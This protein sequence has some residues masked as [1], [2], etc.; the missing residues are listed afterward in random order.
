MSDVTFNPPVPRRPRWKLL[1][2]VSAAVVTVAF[3]SLWGFVPPETITKPVH[4]RRV[5]GGELASK[6]PLDQKGLHFAANVGT[7]NAKNNLSK[8]TSSDVSDPAWFRAESLVICN[9]SDHLLMDRV[10][11]FLLEFLKEKGN[12]EQIDYYPSGTHPDRGRIAPDLYLTLDLGRLAESGVVEKDLAAN[13]RLSLG[14][15]YAASN[16]SQNGPHS[17]P[18]ARL[19]A[20]LSLEHKSTLLGVESSGSRFSMQ[21]KDIAASLGKAVVDEIQSLRRK[22]SPLP[23]LPESSVPAYRESPQFRFLTDLDGRELVSVHGLMLHNETFWHLAS[24]SDPAAAM[25][26][27]HAELSQAEWKGSSPPDDDRS[28][29]LL[30]AHK[31]RRLEV[32][33]EGIGTAGISFRPGRPNQPSPRLLVRYTDSMTSAEIADWFGEALDE[34]DPD[35]ETLLALRRYGNNDQRL[36]LMERAMQQPPRTATGWLALSQHYEWKKDTNAAIRALHCAFVYSQLE[37]ESPRNSH[38]ESHAKKLN[39]KLDDLRKIPAEIFALCGIPRL[40]EETPNHTIDF[41]TGQTA[42]FWTGDPDKW[43][44]VGTAVLP[45]HQE[46]VRLLTFKRD[47]FGIQTSIGTPGIRREQL[48]KQ[49][50]TER[51]DEILLELQP[52]ETGGWRLI[53]TLNLPATSRP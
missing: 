49:G 38:I 31:S 29:H 20:L 40:D 48:Q 41:Q 32:F 28:P 7:L 47:S 6:S 24:A 37:V 21:G 30:M 50:Q 8:V 45:D 15:S 16:H 33:P 3:A 22:H 53:G 4:L 5:D 11:Q 26:Q 51:L 25:K 12:F 14:T 17:P 13:V 42:A 1:M 10:G 36:R 52:A 39:L 44:L 35:L 2:G 23:P 19:R 27:I 46:T 43:L 18:T 9:L 34:T